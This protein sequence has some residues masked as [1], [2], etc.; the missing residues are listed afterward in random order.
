MSSSAVSGSS[1][2]SRQ[3]Q[4]STGSSS[5]S[6]KTNQQINP[7]VLGECNFLN[8]VFLNYHKNYSSALFSPHLLLVVANFRSSLAHQISIYMLPRGDSQEA[9]IILAHS[10]GL[11]K[12]FYWLKFLRIWYFSR[13]LQPWDLWNVLTYGQSFSGPSKLNGIALYPAVCAVGKFIVA[14]PFE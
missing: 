7:V 10:P 1:G 13:S 11:P 4:Q 8:V 14:P 5:S 9:K 6:Y 2:V 12:T 3:L